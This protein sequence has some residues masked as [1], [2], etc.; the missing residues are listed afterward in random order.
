MTLRLA[1][2]IAFVLPFA[3]LSCSQTPPEQQPGE[4][5]TFPCG[6]LNCEVTTPN[7][8]WFKPS[9]ASQSKNELFRLTRVTGELEKKIA[10][11]TAKKKSVDVYYLNMFAVG[12]T[13]LGRSVKPEE[14]KALLA[15]KEAVLAEEKDI[16]QTTSGYK[17]LSLKSSSVAGHPALE[18]EYSGKDTD[19][20]E[21][22]HAKNI[23]VI[24]DRFIFTLH[25]F[26]LD[27]E[28]DK[29]LPEFDKMAQTFTFAK[30]EASPPK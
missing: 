11:E 22:I 21:P 8:A 12:V 13:D 30:R 28:D 29:L 20:G 5:F 15:D 19:I 26:A 24:K 4:K 25:A 7:G 18:L 27:A 1:Q 3:L 2:I 16:Q 17:R 9:I 14:A 10:A 23:Y 6:P